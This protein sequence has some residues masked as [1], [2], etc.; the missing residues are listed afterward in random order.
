MGKRLGTTLAA[1]I[2]LATA[3]C[4]SGATTG[5]GTGAGDPRPS[6]EA[7]GLVGHAE[8]VET[9][10]EDYIALRQEHLVSRLAAEGIVGEGFAYGDLATAL[11]GAEAVQQDLLEHQEDLENLARPSDL[12][13][14]FKASSDHLR[15]A[16]EALDAVLATRDIESF[17]EEYGKYLAGLETEVHSEL[18]AALGLDDSAGLTPQ[19]LFAGEVVYTDELVDNSNEWRSASS[20]PA[21]SLGFAGE[22]IEV[23]AAPG[24]TY[25]VAPMNVHDFDRQDTLISVD[26]LV[27]EGDGA[28]TYSYGIGCP[29]EYSLGSGIRAELGGGGGQAFVETQEQVDGTVEPLFYNYIEGPHEAFRAGEVNHLDVAC[30]TEG[31]RTV[32]I[33]WVNGEIGSGSS[34]PL[35]MPEGSAGNGDGALTVLS[36]LEAPPTVNVRFDNWEVYELSR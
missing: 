20:G 3:G 22:E 33:M 21:G 7:A 5:A 23:V 35:P 12:D 14:E 2:V 9:L 10:V 30:L 31:D 28:E 1:A 6:P 34:F 27:V 16:A 18:R 17:Q 8:E 29:A 11:R 26:T 13:D 15:E 4:D 36:D 19:E 25:V 24:G 32:V